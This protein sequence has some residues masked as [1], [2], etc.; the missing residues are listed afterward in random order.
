M[1]NDFTLKNYKNLKK[2]KKKYIDKNSLLYNKIKLHL[3]NIKS[4]NFQNYQIEKTNINK[5][6]LNKMIDTMW[7]YYGVKD[8]LSKLDKEYVISWNNNNIYLKC[9][10]NKFDKINK[11]LPYLIRMINYI[12]GNNIEKLDIY[13]ILSPLKKYIDNNKKI[14]PKNI[15]SGYTDTLDRYIFIWRE[16]EFEKV[17]FH[18]LIHFFNHDHR[19][20][21]FDHYSE[22]DSLFE[23][24]TD[25][26]AIIY[27]LIYISN[28]TKADLIKLIN[29]EFSF[30]S[31]QGNMIYQII[32]N[33]NPKLV[34]PAFSY[35]VLK[36]M[37]LN[38]CVSNNF[39]KKDYNNLFIYNK[40]F[41][42]IIKKFVSLNEIHFFNFDSCRM[43]YFE[44][45]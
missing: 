45:E 25:F 13:L 10:T 3:K 9:T 8:E 24:I 12:K 43:S 40:K 6:K 44:L 38:Y 39:S 42:K 14:S 19:D 34:S 32:K 36:T 37:L 23:A 35:F 41:N 21:T 30:M 28:V 4:I 29:Y 22:Y 15:N 31:N 26:K 7:V 11:R 1:W 18:E 2:I 33:H 27:N 5:H 16:E 20:E 17:L